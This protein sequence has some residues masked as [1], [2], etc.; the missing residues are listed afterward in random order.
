MIQLPAVCRF[1]TIFL[2]IR[3]LI[4][5]G[6]ALALVA[7]GRAQS[8]GSGALGPIDEGDAVTLTGNTHPLARAEFDR[9]VVAPETRLERLVMLLQPDEDRQ[10]QLDELTEAQQRPGSAGYRRWLTPEQYGSRFGASP[11][12]VARVAG[13]LGSHGFTVEPVGPSRRLLRGAPPGEDQERH[14]TEGQGGHSFRIFRGDYSCRSR[15]GASW[16]RFLQK[17]ICSWN[18]F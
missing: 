16:E 11:E 13:W 18:V 17:T 14:G 12:D 4:V 8:A 5:C 6:V 7:S 15:F 10:R 1:R 9:G 2:K 3:S